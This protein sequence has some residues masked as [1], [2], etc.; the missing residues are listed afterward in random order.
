MPDRLDIPAEEIAAVIA[1]A[2]ELVISYYA[3]LPGAPVLVP[4]TA[5]AL[6]EALREP[7]PATGS[8]FQPLLETIRNIVFRFSRHNGT[9]GFFG[10]IASPGTPITAV[11]SMIQAALNANV[12]GWRSS[13]AA[14]ELEHLVID[15]F[16]EMLG[17]PASAAGL[18]VSGG[19]M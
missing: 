17:Y 1:A 8:D 16:K 18:L 14:A 6:R 11:G 3:G 10:Y 19:S 4:T 13:P 2:S 5:D 12:T 7:L 15:W 9:P